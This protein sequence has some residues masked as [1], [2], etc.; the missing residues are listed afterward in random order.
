[1]RIK[2]QRCVLWSRSVLDWLVNNRVQSVRVH[3]ALACCRVKEEGSVQAVVLE[4][5]SSASGSSELRLHTLSIPRASLYAGV[6]R[7][8]SSRM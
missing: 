1:M 6:D 4:A 8:Q 7:S 2:C 5:A 3:V